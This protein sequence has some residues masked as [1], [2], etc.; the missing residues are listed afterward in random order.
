MEFE[1]K[2]QKKDV[3]LES[4]VADEDV[5]K[6]ILKVMA[7]SAKWQEHAKSHQGAHLQLLAAPGFE[8]SAIEPLLK[9]TKKEPQVHLQQR[10]N[11]AQEF[12]QEKVVNVYSQAQNLQGVY[13]SN[14]NFN[15]AYGNHSHMMSLGNAYENNPN[16]MVVAGCPCGL[17]LQFTASNGKVVEEKKEKSAVGLN[18]MYSFSHSYGG[19]NQSGYQSQ[20]A[21]YGNKQNVAVHGF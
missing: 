11:T 6:A 2:T 5:I 10:L 19:N 4:Y 7:K 12:S 1:F 3:H 8:I 13:G 18:Q 14:Q 17:I 15:A 16:A 9:Q 21:G 20:S